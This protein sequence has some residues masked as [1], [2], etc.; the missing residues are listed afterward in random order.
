MIEQSDKE[1]LD[2]FHRGEYREK[3]FELLV[4][5]YQ[6]KLYAVIR[7]IVIDH[8]DT[9]DVLQNT[10]IKAWKGMNSFREEARL[11][12]WLYRIASNEALSF[13]S[14]SKKNLNSSIENHFHLM[15][16][17]KSDST[18]H[19]GDE[20]Q[21]FLQLAIQTLPEKQRVVFLMKYYDEM[22]YEE[23]AEVLETSVGALKA[24]YH[25]AAKKI[26]EYLQQHALNLSSGLE[27]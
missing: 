18:H 5:K 9:A 26:E 4:K 10:F 21:K 19:T 1:I 16:E 27:S 14:R 24:S 11:Y 8:D 17:E 25:I 15:A 20:I 13:I 6:R 7:R 2:L 12:T 3:A 22:K 23:M